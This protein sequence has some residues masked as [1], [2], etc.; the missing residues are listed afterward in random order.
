MSLS[1][2]F[3]TGGSGFL[4]GHCIVSALAAGHEVRATVAARKRPIV[5]AMLAAA[6]V[7]R[8]QQLTFASADLTSD[9]GWAEAV[10]GCDYVLHTASPFPAVQPDDPTN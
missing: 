9:D 7:G 6:G 8:R 3:I 5:R 10:A 1:N 4:G 2:I